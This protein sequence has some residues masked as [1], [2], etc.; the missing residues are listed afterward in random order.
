MLQPEN[1]ML[2]RSFIEQFWDE[3]VMHCE[4]FDYEAHEAE[5]ILEEL[6]NIK[7]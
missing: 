7:E 4:Q 5:S 2:V 1:Y 6:E 3:F